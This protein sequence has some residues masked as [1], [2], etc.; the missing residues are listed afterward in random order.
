[1]AALMKEQHKNAIDEAVHKLRREADRRA[2]SVR[3]EID[4]TSRVVV[5]AFGQAK[6][7]LAPQRL[8]G[9]G[10]LTDD[11]VD[12]VRDEPW[13]AAMAAA[14]M[15]LVVGAAVLTGQE[16]VRRRRLWRNR[17]R[18]IAREARER[19]ESEL[20]HVQE[21]AEEI[22]GRMTE[23]MRGRATILG[24]AA[25]GLALLGIASR[26]VGRRSMPS[27]ADSQPVG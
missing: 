16:R 13:L 27:G 9:M 15:G 3:Q 24:A 5:G 11:V 23:A 10:E 6:E 21:R 2:A 19:A 12:V 25:L 22:G 18:R 4:D 8:A 26:L 20:G 7:A 17:A 1:M 14:G